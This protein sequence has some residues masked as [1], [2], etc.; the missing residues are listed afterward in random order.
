M[1]Y[2]VKLTPHAIAQIQ[3]TI[4]YISHILLVPETARA[5]ADYL[6][7]K[8]AGL[9]TMPKGHPAVEEE[10]W[11]SRGY[12]KLL[13]KNFIIYYYVDDTDKIVWVT[14]VVYGKRDQLNALK[15][16]PF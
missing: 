1:K 2:S 8:I 9:D 6:E 13:V 3:E 10:P 5:W 16:M 4:A 15:N 7:E 11:K 14:A 12:R